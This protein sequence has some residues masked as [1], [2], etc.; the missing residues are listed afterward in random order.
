MRKVRL[1]GDLRS[2]V[3]RG[4]CLQNAENG[5]PV[6]SHPQLEREGVHL[7]VGDML[8]LWFF[9]SSFWDAAM[10]FLL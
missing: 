8:G 4:W 10:F 3:G 5:G 9:V 6:L 2:C 1:N 7:A